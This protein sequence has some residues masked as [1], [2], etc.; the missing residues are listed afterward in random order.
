[1]NDLC[2]GGRQRYGLLETDTDVDNVVGEERRRH[3]QYGRR[4]GLSR[5]LTDKKEGP[6][7]SSESPHTIYTNT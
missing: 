4:I 1:M 5:G 2:H 7:R 3:L 6:V